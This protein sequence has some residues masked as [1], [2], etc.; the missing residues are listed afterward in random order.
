MSEGSSTDV[1]IGNDLECSSEG[2][3][4]YNGLYASAVECAAGAGAGI[5]AVPLRA[6]IVRVSAGECASIVRGRISPLSIDHLSPTTA[7]LPHELLF[8]VY[9]VITSTD[10]MISAN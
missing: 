3:S 1:V 7:A 9:D 4:E 5:S 8:T 6:A 10:G 2:S